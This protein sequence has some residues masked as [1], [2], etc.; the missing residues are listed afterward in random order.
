MGRGPYGP[1]MEE[2]AAVAAASAAAAAAWTG[3]TPAPDGRRAPVKVKLQPMA[4]PGPA[5]P[6][7]VERTDNGLRHGSGLPPP[8]ATAY[9]HE[10][11]LPDKTSSGQTEPAV[12]GEAKAALPS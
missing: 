3:A 8:R 12:Q 1:K 10:K 2:A 5:T 6:E 9:R 4:E 11:E 7:V